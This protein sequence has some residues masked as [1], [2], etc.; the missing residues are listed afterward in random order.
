MPTT[1]LLAGLLTYLGIL[2]S[3][4]TIVHLRELYEQHF[5]AKSAADPSSKLYPGSCIP[6]DSGGWTSSGSGNMNQDLL[7]LL[8]AAECFI[9][10]FEPGE[11][12]IKMLRIKIRPIF[13]SDIKICIN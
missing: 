8:L 2:S 10:G 1:A 5:R 4:K 13:V 12:V 7:T 3:L 11:G 6:N 9:L